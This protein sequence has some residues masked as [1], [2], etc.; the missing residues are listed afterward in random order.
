MPDINIG[1]ITEALN[2]KEDRD[3]RNTDTGSGA[4]AV[5]D[6]QTPNA[7]NNYTWYRK[8]ASG[9]V[10][11]G[12]NQAPAGVEIILPIPMMDTNYTLTASFVESASGNYPIWSQIGIKK[13][14]TT[15]KVDAAGSSQSWMIC[16]MAAS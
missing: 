7:G 9:W 12:G 4:D 3:L 2:D 14:T 13:T 1:A 6:F 16:G 10:E 5:I 8:Y 15:I 11:Q